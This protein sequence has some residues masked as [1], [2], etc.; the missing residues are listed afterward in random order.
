MSADNWAVCPRCHASGASAPKPKP[1]IYGR[2]SE[3]QYKAFLAGEYQ[4]E[5]AK[6]AEDERKMREDY[7]IFVSE[8]GVLTV[9]YS[10]SC[11]EC[12]FAFKFSHEEAIYEP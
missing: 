6:D 4:G 11:Y 12:G 5:I 2:A 8:E 3:E 7:E 10:C 1:P 9:K